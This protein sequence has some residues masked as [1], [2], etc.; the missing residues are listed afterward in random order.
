MRS[1]T[2]RWVTGG[3]ATILALVVSC[4]AGQGGYTAPAQS[5]SL[6]GEFLAF[7]GDFGQWN[8]SENNMP[9]QV[10]EMVP[11]SDEVAAVIYLFEMWLQD[12]G[13]G[14]A[15]GTSNSSQSGSTGFASNSGLTSSDNPTNSPTGSIV[16]GQSGDDPPS[17]LPSGGSG[18]GSL[19]SNGGSGSG[20]L[21]SNGGNDPPGIGSNGGGSSL[22]NG[23]PSQGGGNNSGQQLGG[24]P[25]LGGTLGGGGDPPP[26]SPD[27]ATPEPASLT[28]LAVGGAGLLMGQWLRRRRL[29]V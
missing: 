12:S 26:V 21:P 16:A 18:S 11:A 3:L 4:S 29:A 7:V 1:D 2:S 14:S 8:A 28:L 13:N 22:Q 19:L 15:G 20:S 10:L 25:P 9:M 6:I 17:T 5:N 27:Q 24:S 23:S